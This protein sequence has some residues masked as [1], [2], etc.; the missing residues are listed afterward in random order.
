MRLEDYRVIAE[1]VDGALGSIALVGQPPI[2]AQRSVE[3]SD[4]AKLVNVNPPIAAGAA[5]RL[6]H[7][8][9]PALA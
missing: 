1:P 6:G 8:P 7:S 9:T 5:T 2:A 4:A 3:E